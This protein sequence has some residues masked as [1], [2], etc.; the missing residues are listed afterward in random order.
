[1][2]LRKIITVFFFITILLIIYLVKPSLM[3]NKDGTIK[4]FGYTEEKSI[5]TIFIAIPI[6]AILCYI[7]VLSL[8]LIY[9]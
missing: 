8:E 1:M 2:F 6:I 7:I 9:T 5:I 4:E 3:F